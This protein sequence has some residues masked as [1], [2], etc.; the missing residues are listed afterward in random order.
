MAIR[1]QFVG[2]EPPQDHAQIAN[3]LASYC[4]DEWTVTVRR[5]DD[6]TEHLGWWVSM[7]KPGTHLSFR[8]KLNASVA[9]WDECVSKYLPRSR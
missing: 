2:A 9:E 7:N 5:A 4:S 8:I 6:G 1:V 3:A